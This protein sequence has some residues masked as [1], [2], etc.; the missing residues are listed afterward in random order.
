MTRGL[1]WFVYDQETFY[2]AKSRRI[3]VH[4]LERTTYSYVGENLQKFWALLEFFSR[5]KAKDK[6]SYVVAKPAKFLLC[7][8]FAFAEVVSNKTKGMIQSNELTHKFQDIS[9]LFAL[10]VMLHGLILYTCAVITMW[11]RSIVTLMKKM[12]GKYMSVTQWKM[13]THQIIRPEM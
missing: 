4:H 2:K 5:P 7:L 12:Y 13:P 1:Q 3:N 11:Q 6:I 8:M 10:K 9:K